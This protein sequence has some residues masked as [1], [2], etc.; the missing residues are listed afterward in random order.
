[1]SADYSAAAVANEFLE[2]S[3]MNNKPIT[4]MQLLKLVYIAHGW[5]LAVF[6]KPLF[7]D[8]VQ[9]WRHGPVIPSLFHEFKEFGASSIAK[10]AHSASVVD[11][12]GDFQV[13]A[14]FV[15]KDDHE[16]KQMLKWVWNQYGSMS[17]W[18]LSNLTHLPGTPWDEA[19]KKMKETSKGEWV[20]GWPIDQESIRRHYLELWNKRHATS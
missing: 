8:E 1:M 17:G 15:R 9:A 13:S 11:D 14:P 12:Y 19:M 7:D 2:L 18:E 5:H 6:K 20:K 3:G 16:T 10:M 4:P